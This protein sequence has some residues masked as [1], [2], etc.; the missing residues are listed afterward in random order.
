LGGWNRGAVFID[1]TYDPDTGNGSNGW[2]FGGNRAVSAE[3]PD[4]HCKYALAGEI[5]IGQTVGAGVPIARR[6]AV[7][8]P[9]VR[10]QLFARVRKGVPAVDVTRRGPRRC[11]RRLAKVEQ[12]SIGMPRVGAAEPWQGADMATA[13]ILR[14]TAT[15]SASKPPF[16]RLRSLSEV[17][18][19]QTKYP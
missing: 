10:S 17:R 6:A 4:F 1:R 11:V 19:R 14:R 9:A 3:P 18:S 8:R 2:S 5:D 12:H 13:A 7:C 15:S 16:L